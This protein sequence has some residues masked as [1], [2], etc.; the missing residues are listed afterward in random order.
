[1]N[2]PGEHEKGCDLDPVGRCELEENL[3]VLRRTSVF[4]EIPAQRLR[5]YAYLSRRMRF[6]PGEF[7]FR[8]GDRDNRGYILMTGRAQVIREYKEQSLILNELKE[9]EFFGGLALLSDVQRLFSVRSVTA[10][11]CLTVD[12]ESFRKLVVQFPDVAIK[13]IDVMVRRIVQMEER[14]LEMKVHECLYG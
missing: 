2:S 4:A 3:E 5:L 1:M 9:G 13:A 7:L 6:R 12:R 10:V 8:Q 14:L 11:E